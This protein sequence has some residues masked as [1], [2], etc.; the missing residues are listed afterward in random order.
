MCFAEHLNASWPTNERTDTCTNARTKNGYEH[1]AVVL[2]PVCGAHFAPHYTPPPSPHLAR[3]YTGHHLQYRWGTKLSVCLHTNT[4]TTSHD[5][6]PA[7]E[8]VARQLLSEIISHANPPTH[9]HTHTHTPIDIF[10]FTYIHTPSSENI[11]KQLF[12]QDSMKYVFMATIISRLLSQARLVGY[13][14]APSLW[15]ICLRVY[16]EDNAQLMQKHTHLT[17]I[18]CP[19]S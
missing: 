6:K 1:P 12:T 3:H 14:I 18:M 7:R 11:A 13:H 5:R 10:I 17:W 15:F 9:P 8:A 16:D 2:H 4:V 19:P